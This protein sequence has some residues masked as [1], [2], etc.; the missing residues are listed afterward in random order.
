VYWYEDMLLNKDLS[1]SFP[2]WLTVAGEP[3]KL[4]KVDDYT[5]RLSFAAPYGLLPQQ[6]AFRSDG[7]FYPAHYLKQ[8]HAK[9]VSKEE[10]DK[11][12][13]E[14]QLESWD[15]LYGNKSDYLRNVDL[16]V[17]RPWKIVQAPPKTIVI[18]ERNPYYWKVDP[19]GNQLPYIDRQRYTLVENVELVNMKGVAGEVDMQMRHMAFS[20]YSL[21]KENADKGGYRVFLW[22]MGETGIV[23]FPNLTLLKDDTLRELMRDLRFRQALSMAIDRDEINELNYNGMASPIQ[24]GFPEELRG[25][26]ELWAPFEYNLDKANALLDEIGLTEKSSAGYRLRPDGKELSLTIEGLVAFPTVSDVCELVVSY[27]KKLGINAA[28][29][30][31]TYDLWWDRIYTSEYQVA[32]YAQ[33]NLSPVVQAIYARAY[34]PIEHSTYWAPEWG[35]WYVTGGKAGEEPTGDA[36]EAQKI[37]DELKMTTD[38]DKQ[39]ELM[40]QIYRLYLKNVWSIITVG[41][42]PAPMIVKK[43]FRNVP[44][45][46]IN[47]WPLKS[48]GYTRPEQYFFKSS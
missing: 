23:L 14:A 2:S 1:P 40:T 19:D 38:A 4:E 20:N 21:F 37:Y 31:I 10:L 43:N 47:A 33:A 35:N 15:Q 8:F 34:A 7:I 24:D 46:G 18:F 11:M 39:V 48:P 44:E 16:P 13:Q 5:I 26:E 6:M 30:P 41:R 29:K 12:V 9:Y 45:K 32:G 36:R 25:E 17:I 27:W 3:M 28:F 42:Y 22:Q